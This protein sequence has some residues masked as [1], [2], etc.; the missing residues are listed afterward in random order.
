MCFIM[1]A[2]CHMYFEHIKL[3]YLLLSNSM[4][5]GGVVQWVSLE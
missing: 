4:P 1:K 3:H 5:F 2:L